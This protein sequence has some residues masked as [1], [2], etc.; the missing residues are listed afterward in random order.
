[1]A[2]FCVD[3]TIILFFLSN[4]GAGFFPM[5]TAKNIYLVEHSYI[6]A[7]L[8]HIKL[9]SSRGLRLLGPLPASAT[10]NHVEYIPT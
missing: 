3:L 6:R 2:A 9:S 7:T 8:Q 10:P 5:E 4:L 1:M